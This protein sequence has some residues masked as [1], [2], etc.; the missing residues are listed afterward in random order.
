[1]QRFAGDDSNA[2]KDVV[3]GDENWISCYDLETK[4]G[5]AKWVF[6]FEEL[7]TEG[8]LRRSVGKKMVASFFEMT[9]RYATIVLKDKQL[10][11]IGTLTIVYLLFWKNFRKNDLA[12]GFSFIISVPVF[13]D[14]IA[15]V[16]PHTDRQTTNNLG[17]LGIEILAHLPAL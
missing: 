7:P 16:S 9:G 17:M 14:Q 11:Q 15:I 1:M 5:S 4:R 8:K 10:L 3:T 2:V 6:P 12:I 13:G